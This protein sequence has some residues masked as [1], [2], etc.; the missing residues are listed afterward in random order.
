MNKKGN[1]KNN[2]EKI[3]LEFNRSKEPVKKIMMKAE[4]IDSE[5]KELSDEIELLRKELAHY[6]NIEEEYLDR[7]KRVHADYDNYRKRTLK[8]QVDTISRANKGLIEKL[9]PVIDSFEQALTENS[10]NVKNTDEFFKGFKLIFKQLMDT[11][12]KA[13][14]T[15]ID[16]VGEEFNP[17]ECEAAVTEDVEDIEEGKV[18]D[19][20]RKGYRLNDFLIR[21]AV[22]KVCK[23]N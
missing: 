14:V 12:V 17:H 11:L 15:V 19:V 18:L 13:G 16:P 23:R 20:L 6:K 5:I 7:L 3:K 8:E 22:V 9:L 21:P 10:Y 1:G 4:D 2:E